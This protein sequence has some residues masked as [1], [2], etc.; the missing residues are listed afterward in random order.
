MK[1][2]FLA[3]L[4]AFQYFPASTQVQEIT[5]DS[6]LH[7]F[8]S[9]YPIFAQL[10]LQKQTEAL[11]LSSVSKSW[12]PQLNIIGQATYQSDV[13]AIEI[14]IPNIL[15]PDPLS[16]DQYKF[17]A[18]LQQLIFDGFSISR[19]KNALRWQSQMEYV[20]NDIELYK[21]EGR[22]LV[23][24]FSALILNEQQKINSYL[25]SDLDEQILKL[26]AAVDAGVLLESALQSL[27]AEKLSTQQRTDEIVYKL[28][29]IRQSL[30]LMTGRTI[31]DKDQLLLPELP[32]LKNQVNRKELLWS[33]MYS[34]HA[35]AQWKL[36]QSQGIP[37][38]L[39][40]GQAGYSNPALNFLKKG[41]DSYYIAGLRLSWN[42]SPMYSFR[43]D[44]ELFRLGKSMAALQKDLFHINNQQVI[45]EQLLEIERLQKLMESDA[46]I[47][48]YRTNIKEITRSQLDEG[49]ITSADYIRELNAEEKAKVNAILH[50]IQNIQAHFTL[51]Y[52]YGQ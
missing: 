30:S 17:Y 12:F 33:D 51:N 42:L 34:N 4:I 11:Q 21:A 45:N 52:Y 3:I 40:F 46:L 44:K 6:C 27:L 25:I 8:R 5:L 31:G 48:K 36:K 19:Q 37:K 28:K 38:I 43:N 16:K 32:I 7:W 35:E 10:Q 14:D 22:V 18:D 39:L 26:Q 20:K 15:L 50:K 24:F 1:S 47:L 23:L 2:Y 9:H 29:H 41:F 13:T 49:T